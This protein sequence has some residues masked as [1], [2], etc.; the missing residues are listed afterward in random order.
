MKR[1]PRRALLKR[2]QFRES[3]VILFIM[4]VIMMNFPFLHI[5]N[6]SVSIFGMPLL[7]L[8]FMGGWA[9]SIFVIYLFTLAVSRP[10]TQPS[11]HSES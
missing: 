5:V 6:K 2:L 11:E 7:F 10:E 4:G 1:S 8:Y 3:W 9:V